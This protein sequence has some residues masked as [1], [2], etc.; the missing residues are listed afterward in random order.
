MRVISYNLRENHASGEL[1]ALAENND[2]DVLCL[3]EADTSLLPAELGNL[4]L[5]DS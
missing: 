1:I 3:Q 5:A 2:L 4:H